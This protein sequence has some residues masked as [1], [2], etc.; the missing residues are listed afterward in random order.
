MYAAVPG[1]TPV[2]L[3]G[4]VRVGDSERKAG[5]YSSLNSLPK[6]KSSI[7]MFPS[8][9]ILAFAGFTSLW[10]TPLSCATSRPSVICRKRGSGSA[11]LISFCVSLVLRTLEA[12]S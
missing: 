7:L 10:T 6:P 9:V 11:S 3:P 8:S 1:T 2:S 4:H 5:G 12:P